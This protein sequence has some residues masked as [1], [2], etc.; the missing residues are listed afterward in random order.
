MQNIW[1]FQSIYDLRFFNCPACNYK[2]KSK[3]EFV[4][5]ICNIHPESINNLI[6]NIQDGSIDDIKCPWNR[7]EESTEII[8]ID[9]K[10][11]EFI[12]EEPIGN[13]D[14]V[15]EET[16][17]LEQDVFEMEE[18]I[19]IIKSDPEVKT[20]QQSNDKTPAVSNTSNT[21]YYKDIT[22]FKLRKEECNH[23]GLKF[24]TDEVLQKHVSV[25]HGGINVEQS[26]SRTQYW[27]GLAR[28]QDAKCSAWG[29]G[30]EQAFKCE[31][32]SVSFNTDK[33]L[34]IHIHFLHEKSENKLHCEICDITFKT[35]QKS[36]DH[37]EEIH[38]GIIKE[39]HLT[40][41]QCGKFFES[42]KRSDGRDIAR[43]N[44]RQH[45]R[46]VH[47]NYEKP[48]KEPISVK[49]DQCEKVFASKKGLEEHKRIIHEGLRYECTVCDYTCAQKSSLLRHTKIVHEGILHQCE[50]CGQVHT[51]EKGLQEHIMAIHENIREYQCDECGKYQVSRER[52]LVHKSNAHGDKKYC[53]D[54]CGKKFPTPSRL[55]IHD[56]TVHKRLKT[57]KCPYC[58]ETFSAKAS[59]K[60]HLVS[61]H[62]Q[63]KKVGC[64]QCEKKFTNKSLLKKHILFVHEG[65]KNY[66]CQFCQKRFPRNGSLKLHI[67]TVHDGL[68]PHKC[69]F[70]GTAY[71]QK[72]DLKRH[73]LRAHPNNLN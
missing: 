40:C 43:V 42:R 21:I 28:D 38:L 46:M 10:T 8:D 69:N 70:C 25:V 50:R 58:K 17:T 73:K 35:M 7:K 63:E 26:K 45:I 2:D 18:E 6:L 22:S 57:I 61:K 67:T 54:Q 52:L 55:K 13:E 36:M 66:L 9:V 19:S 29:D 27:P 71:G 33:H 65:I 68:K 23:C 4:F 12:N 56:D 34:K 51:T 44:L 60:F 3:Q 53:C 5:H 49:C 1:G 59:L 16:N 62:E 31:L 64:D 47:E 48:K 20:F 41:Q 32:C 72:G 30:D 15:N 14:F 11:E 37:F 24:P 39:N